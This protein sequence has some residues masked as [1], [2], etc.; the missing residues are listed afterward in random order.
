MD[1][2][3]EKRPSGI[4][5]VGELPWGT[6]FCQFYKTKKDLTD[7]LV[8]YF[9]AGLDNNE[10]CVLVTSDFFTKEDAKKFMKKE[11]LA[12]SITWKKARWKSFLIQIGT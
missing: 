11:S 1:P 12:L 8:P 4:A 2:N 9:K 6:H 3:S 5:L 10:K 7:M